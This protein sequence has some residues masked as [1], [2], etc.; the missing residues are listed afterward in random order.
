MDIRLSYGIYGYL[1]V[2]LS[3]A[4]A[5]WVYVSDSTQTWTEQN[6]AVVCRQLGYNPDG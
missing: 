6:A 2:F 3:D 5:S 4:P 1:Q